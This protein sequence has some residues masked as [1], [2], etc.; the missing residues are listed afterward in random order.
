MISVKETLCGNRG[1]IQKLK[2]DECFTGLMDILQKK[3]RHDVATTTK[4]LHIEVDLAAI[5]MLDATSREKVIDLK[6][7]LEEMRVM[8][9]DISL[10]DDATRAWF[11][12]K[13]QAIMSKQD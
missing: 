2:K 4:K 1:E 3:H 6:L 13:K 8:V 11:E 5:A 12:K 9:A 7:F 10:M